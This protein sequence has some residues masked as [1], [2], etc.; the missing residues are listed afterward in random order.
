[1]SAS[2]RK[3]TSLL[4][5][6]ALCAGSAFAQE[7]KQKQW[8][9]QAESD[10]FDKLKVDPNPNS[11]LELLNKWAKDYPTSDLTLERNLAFL[12]TYQQLNRPKDVIN[13][14]QAILKEDPNNMRALSAIAGAVYSINPPEPA[15]LDAAE[16]AASQLVN[17]IDAVFSAEAQEATPEYKGKDAEWAKLKS[18]TKN[19]GQMTLGWVAMAKKDNERA[20]V[21]LTKAVQ[22]NPQNAQ[23]SYW[24]G[25]VILAQKKPEKQEAALFHIARAAAYDGPGALNPDGRKQV[26]DYVK[27][28]YRTYTGGEDG[29]EKLMETAKANHMPPADFDIVSIREKLEE[30]MKE[31]AALAKSDPMLYL[32]RNIKNELTGQSGAAYFEQNMKEALLPGGVEVEGRKVTKFKGKLVSGT[33]EVRPKELVIQ[34]DPSGSGGDATLKFDSPLAGKVEPDTEIEFDGVA[35][36]YTSEPFMVVFSVEKESLVGW[37]GGTG[38]PSAKKAPAAKKGAPAKKK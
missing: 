36:S 33:P 30:Q 21:E 26:A 14:G 9:D 8:K 11:R 22:L 13:A 1:M 25:N 28:A 7:K 2:T 10:L 27:K 38:A 15:F 23:I 3:Y 4:A 5:I 24:L 17:N 16:K 32:W 19:F 37:K 20:E 34:V 6:F 29:L 12:V 18:D 31:Q 35:T